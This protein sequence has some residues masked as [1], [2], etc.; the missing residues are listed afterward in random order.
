MDAGMRAE[1][2]RVQLW[3]VHLKKYFQWGA[4]YLLIANFFATLNI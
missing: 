2:E 4:F 3:Q 1:E